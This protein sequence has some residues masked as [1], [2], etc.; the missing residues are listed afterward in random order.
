MPLL[1]DFQT[2]LRPCNYRA[3]WF[4]HKL[5]CLS[6]HLAY[7][8]SLNDWLLPPKNV[9]QTYHAVFSSIYLCH[10]FILPTIYRYLVPNRYYLCST[11]EMSIAFFNREIYERTEAKYAQVGRSM[12]L[13]LVKKRH[14]NLSCSLFKHLSMSFIHFT[15]HIG[16]Y[17]VPMYMKWVLLLILIV[18]FTGEQI[19]VDDVAFFKV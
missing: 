6:V 15:Y 10:S 18:K 12:I 17:M 3:G 13:F 14:A 8:V 7:E 1:S 11:D 4:R 16:R 2:F 5:Q 9:M 19:E